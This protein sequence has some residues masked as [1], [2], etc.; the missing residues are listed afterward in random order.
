MTERVLFIG[1]IVIFNNQNIHFYD[2]SKYQVIMYN[3]NKL[4]SPE[5]QKHIDFH[6]MKETAKS[7]VIKC[8][9]KSYKDPA[10]DVSWRRAKDSGISR[11]SYWFCDKSDTGKNQAKLYWSYLKN[12]IGEGIACADFENGSWQNWKELY[13]FIY[14]FQQLS[15]FPNHK[16]AIYTGYYYFMENYPPKESQKWFSQFPLWIASYT[17][18]PNYVK[19]PPLWDK[20][21]FWQYGTPS[22]G[23]S[24]GVHSIEID[25]NYF[26]GTM[27]EFNKYFE[28]S[29][30]SPPDETENHISKRK[31]SIHY[32]DKSLS[33]NLK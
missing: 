25:G 3:G 15:G 10:F 2:V 5:K 26:N 16:I 13:N 11:G 18:S 9:Q 28:V 19:I 8:G 6:K 21:T 1:G 20:A 23:L 17:S 29:P 12:D 31:M 33:F 27:E 22:I 30:V 14:E 4:L 24:A 7:V 32:G